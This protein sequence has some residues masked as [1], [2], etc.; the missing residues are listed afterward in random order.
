MF[1]ALQKAPVDHEP[2]RIPW[3]LFKIKPWGFEV[4]VEWHRR[5]VDEKRN[6]KL[7]ILPR[8]KDPCFIP[9][10]LRSHS[11]SCFSYVKS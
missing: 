11:L 7:L 9:I 6:K 2:M 8:Y 5:E 10:S 4:G 1:I 3:T